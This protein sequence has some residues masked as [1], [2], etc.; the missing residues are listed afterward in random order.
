MGPLVRVDYL[1]VRGDGSLDL[2]FFSSR[3]D[4]RSDSGYN[5]ETAVYFLK[6]NFETGLERQES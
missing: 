1:L 3:Y 5:L 2:L 6:L 4:K